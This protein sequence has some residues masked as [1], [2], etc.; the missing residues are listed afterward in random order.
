MLSDF[1]TEFMFKE[2]YGNNF[3]HCLENILTKL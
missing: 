3:K 2:D 1:W